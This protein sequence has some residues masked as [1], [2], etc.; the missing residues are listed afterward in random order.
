[1]SLQ[2][3]TLTQA[4]R[5]FRSDEAGRLNTE[6]HSFSD[7]DRVHVTSKE[8]TTKFAESSEIRWVLFL[9]EPSTT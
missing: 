6:S 8:G 7:P 5:S 4:T 1:M 2:K 3:S 9:W